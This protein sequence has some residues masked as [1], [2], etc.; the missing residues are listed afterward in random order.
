VLPRSIRVTLTFWNS[1]V[2]AVTLLL[3]SGLIYTTLRE[4]LY[5]EEDRELEQLAE[6]LASP[7]IS[8]FWASSH[9]AFDQVLEDFIGSRVA[10]KFVQITLASGQPG[11]RSGNLA[12]ILLPL[13]QS[14]RKKAL[15]GK[16]DF[17]TLPKGVT[18]HP[19][20]V[21]T[22]PVMNDGVLSAIIQVGASLQQQKETLSSVLLV[23]AVSI[24]LALIFAAYGA[25]M[26]ACKALRP[27]EF[28]TASARR[29]SAENLSAR[30]QVVNPDDEI[31]KLTTT[32]NE[33]LE[34][35]ESSFSRI[36]HFSSDVSHEL[37]TPL[38][39]MRGEMEVAVR[40]ARDVEEQRAI[41]GSCLD[42]VGR[43]TQIIDQ[44][45]EMARIESGQ[46]VLELQDVD[47]SGLVKSIVS[48][49][50]LL[51]GAERVTVSADREEAVV[52]GDFRRL[53]A[54][55]VA[56]LDNALR[57]SPAE[58]P[59]T[60]NLGVSDGWVT[61]A[62]TDQGKGIAPEELSRIFE[63]FYRVD[64][65]RNRDHGGIGLGLSLVRLIAEAHG[66]TVTAQSTLG[67]GSTFIVTLPCLEAEAPPA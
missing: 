49:E 45:L 29:I 30:L 28:I 17:F 66:G 57:Y 23:L 22:Y 61:V 7:T 24:P 1:L 10:G 41:M 27:V 25:W 20:R 4:N 39:I 33:M 5:A 16:E 15:Q 47:L 12:G 11:S 42:E 51:S 48:H 19:L 34:R 58:L 32:M 65:S 64:S 55:F 21:I 44:L 31:G 3:F 14:Q 46:L 60:V 2:L 37:R 56:L 36:R 8:L 6:S 53:Q 67:A 26:L 62:I 13:D 35:L 50:K 63:T 54:L 59:V 40:W 43:M 38:T 9:S 18:G 52:R